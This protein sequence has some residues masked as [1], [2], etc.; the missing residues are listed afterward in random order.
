MCSIYLEMPKRC[1]LVMV[2]LLTSLSARA[3]ETSISL[4]SEG[5]VEL[6]RGNLA[7]A[8]MLM[9]R[10][11]D[12]DPSDP[13]ALYY[14]G[15]VRSRSDE[16]EG[17][18]ADLRRAL[19]IKSDFAEA[20]LDLGVSLV[21]AGEYAQAEPFLQEV[22][23]YPKL[24]GN[25]ILFLGI[26]RLR[27]GE[28]AASLVDFE[29][30]PNINP[31][32]AT[33]ALYYRAVA[34]SRLGRAE[35]A[36]L[37]F[38]TVIEQ[39]PGTE[40]AAEASNFLVALEKGLGEAKRYELYMGYRIEYDSNVVLRLNGQSTADLGVQDD[41]DVVY[42]LRLGGRYS[43]W[44]G[45]NT[46][47]SLGYDFFQRVYTELD[48]YNLQGHSPTLHW[49]AQWGNLRLGVIAKYQ[50]YLLKSDPYLQRV[51]G[52]PWIAWHFGDWGRTELSYRVRWSD[53]LDN[54]PGGTPSAGLGG[55]FSNSK[56]ALDSVSHKPRLRQYFYLD[57]PQRYVALTYAYEKRAPT[58]SEGD[59]FEF[60]AHEFQ[61][62]AAT[63][64]VYGLD[65]FASYAYRREDYN[66]GDRLDEPHVIVAVLRWPLTGWFAVSFGYFGEVH[67]SNHFEYNRHIGSI[68]FDL[69]L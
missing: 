58:K 62:A 53:F 66:L 14:R 24:R 59:P 16:L 28:T 51:G 67:Q 39:T 2:V 25:A 35:E 43:V 7:T 36:R 29:Q 57:S 1:G 42:N 9:E 27:Q 55:D 38:E 37:S 30:V 56:D 31:S 63:P 69:A 4:Y 22:S 15:V 68:G 34:L 18:I 64:L 33:T 23:R 17:A 13:Y 61:I 41:S 60:D 20:R 49:T 52:Q 65:L 12:A 40:L 21:Q 47:V 48:Q 19:S 11:V 32:L 46:A 8:S 6:H 5:L 3:S 50:F 26:A 10:A 44:H 54:P 45:D